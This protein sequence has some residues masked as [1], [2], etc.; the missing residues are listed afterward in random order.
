MLGNYKLVIDIGCEVHSELG[1]YA[2]ASFF[3]FQR[4]EI[5]PDAVYLLGRFQ[6]KTNIALIRELIDKNVIKVILSDPV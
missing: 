1:Q 6:F 4:H 5:I 2:D 3:D